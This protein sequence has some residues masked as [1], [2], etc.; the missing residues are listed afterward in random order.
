[1]TKRLLKRSK[2]EHPDAKNW[3]QFSEDVIGL[4]SGIQDRKD[5]FP[6]VWS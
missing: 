4:L 2:Y 3:I 5:E 6:H 1:M